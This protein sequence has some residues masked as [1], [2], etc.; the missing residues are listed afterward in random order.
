[1]MV[2]LSGHLEGKVLV[3]DSGQDMGS[4]KHDSKDPCS[5]PR[6]GRHWH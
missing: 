5:S 4:M 1:M 2:P 6:V 3:L